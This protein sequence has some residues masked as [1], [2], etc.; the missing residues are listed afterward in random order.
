MRQQWLC[1]GCNR[2]SRLFM[3]IYEKLSGDGDLYLTMSFRN[4]EILY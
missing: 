4:L 2:F 3:D 1:D